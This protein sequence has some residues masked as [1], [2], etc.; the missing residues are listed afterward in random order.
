AA[1]TGST[2][3]PPAAPRR[4]AAVTASVPPEAIRRVDRPFRPPQPRD[5][6]P[7]PRTRP[8]VPGTTPP[9]PDRSGRS[10]GGYGPP[11]P[12][13]SASLPP[14]NRSWAAA[15]RPAPTPQGPARPKH[16]R[17]PSRRSPPAQ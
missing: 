14:P 16:L 10:A 2:A 13:R 17:A 15:L 12:R 8:P 7:A 11:R 6:A 3:D 9:E 4:S 5:A 1:A